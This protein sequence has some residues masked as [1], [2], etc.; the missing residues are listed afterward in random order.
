MIVRQRALLGKLGHL[1]PI[2]PNLLTQTAIFL[3][4]KPR[5]V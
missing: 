2:A 3:L 4:E 1:C 5:S